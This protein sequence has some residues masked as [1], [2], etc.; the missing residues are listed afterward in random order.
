MVSNLANTPA[1]KSRVKVKRPTV[2]RM[3]LSRSN[4]VA[5]ILGVNCPPATWMA[6]RREPKVKTMNV[7]VSVMI[8]SII[9]VF[10]MRPN[11]R[12]VVT[13]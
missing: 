6:T 2:K 10:P 12:R 5:M 8:V 1:A 13:R 9:S 7:S 3:E 4:V 11:R